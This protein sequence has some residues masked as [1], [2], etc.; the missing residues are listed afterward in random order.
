[1]S[2]LE[3]ILLFLGIIMPFYIS[4]RNQFS[5]S[6]ILVISIVGLLISHGVFDG[7]R[8]QMIPIYIV[9]IIAIIC[10]FQSWLFFKGNWIR[11]TASGLFLFIFLGFG[12]SLSTILPVFDLPEPTGG[13]EIGSDYFHLTTDEDELLTEQKGDKRELSIK[14]WYPATVE[15][16]PKEIYLNDGDRIGFA[17][18]YGLPK[19]TFNYLKNVKTNTFQK[20][21][22]ATG[23]FP[24]LV[25]SH[26]QY[27]KANGYYALMEEIVSQ[28]FIVLNI[29]H[30]YESVGS[31][32][33]SGEVKLYNQE[34]D[35]K[36]NNQE[37]AD[38][39]WETMEAFKKTKNK[40]EK[41]KLLNGFLKNY[42]AAEISNRWANDINLVINEI[43][44]WEKSTFLSNHIYTSKIGV[45]GHS[46]GASAA[47]QALLDNPKIRAGINIDGVQWG[48]MV[49]TFLSKPF[50]LLSSDWAED[51]PNFNEIAYQNKSKSDF[52]LAKIKNSGHSSFMDIPLIIN[53]KWLNEAGD[54]E[55]EKA[56]KITAEIV[57]NFFEN[58]LNNGNYDL[59]ELG[60]QRPE[61]EIEKDIK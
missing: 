39:I 31:L 5:D 52:Y 14:V 11:R 48:N 56:S 15:N 42:F 59:L 13:Y 16:E 3:I 20:P 38:T 45:F 61:L 43:P 19:S 27:S 6:K 25:F 17:V 46:Q 47:G 22:I 2:Y 18:K 7:F 34:Y 21:S 8:W 37:M 40:A 28:G 53:L 33:P 55:P 49:D 30:T 35:R 50:L 23:K 4:I 51:H 12:S 54:I 9:N 44:N 24:I 57:V 41:S 58:Y 26:G 60:K 10:L 36:H 32:F 1:M 29:N